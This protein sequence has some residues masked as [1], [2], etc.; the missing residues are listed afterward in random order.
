MT[1]CRS[2]ICCAI[3]AALLPVAARAQAADSAASP[4]MARLAKALAGDWLT[5][6]VVQGGSPVPAGAGRRGQMHA[7][8]A[9]GGSVLLSEGHSAGT[10]GGDLRWLTTIWWDQN[11]K[12]YG[13]FTCFRT[14]NDEGCEIRGTAH[15]ENDVFVNQYTE[16]VNGTPTK[17]E[18]RFAA[19][20]PTSHTLT[21]LHDDGHGVMRPYVV[22]H[23]TRQ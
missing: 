21:E 8:L 13:F 7:W 19:I 14:R 4:E 22:S 18:D 12:L 23:D 10:V 6:E 1:N 2:F 20:T 5:V 16:R 15:W 11:A 3:A 17:M 9:A